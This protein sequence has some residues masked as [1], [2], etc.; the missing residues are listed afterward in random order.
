MNSIMRTMIL[1]SLV[2]MI[3]A[4]IL[5]SGCGSSGSQPKSTNT[6]T[7]PNTTIVFSPNYISSLDDLYHWS[8]LP[9]KIYFVKQS[10]WSSFYLNSLPQTAAQSWNIPQAQ[11]FFQVV[12][13]S[14]QADVTCVFI[15]DP[16]PDWGSSQ[17]TNVHFLINNAQ[18]LILSGTYMECAVRTKTGQM[19]SASQLQTAVA[20]G[21]GSVLG[22]YGHS[23]YPEDLMYVQTQASVLGPQVRDYNTA[24]TAY[25]SYFTSS[26]SGYGYS[27]YG[28]GSRG[29][30]FD[31]GTS[32]HNNGV[33]KAGIDPSL[34]SFVSKDN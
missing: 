1:L 8:S 30:L 6:T 21:L 13:Q 34:R 18:K 10:N 16:R 31:L 32:R 20:A 17:V 7:G 5:I 33:P 29:L 19:L 12:S 9:I 22:I 4:S 24:M 2:V 3:A 28:Y 27:G 11:A 26:Y 23:P 15:N 25:H 14:S